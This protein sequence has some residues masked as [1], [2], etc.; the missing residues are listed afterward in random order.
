ME[1]G[2]VT[3]WDDMEAI[4]HYL[5]VNELRVSSKDHPVLITEAAL[6]PM[7]N[8]EKITQILFEKFHVPGKH[9]LNLERYHFRF[10]SYD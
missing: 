7:G 1:H 6:N 2:I 5:F 9:F 10:V 8:R 4:W 3:N